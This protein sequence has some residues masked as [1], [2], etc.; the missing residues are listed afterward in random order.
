MAYTVQPTQPLA[1]DG[2]ALGRV[3][4]Q[5]GVAKDAAV[6]VT[7]P[8]ALT[9]V[10][11]LYRHGYAKAAFVHATHVATMEAADALL[12][13]HTCGTRELAAVLQGGGCLREGGVLIVQTPTELV[14]EGYDTIDGLLLRLGYLV[15][16]RVAEK[17]RHIY[18][19]RRQGFGGFK[20]AA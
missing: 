11:W 10:F 9:A 5:A 1:A 20:Q 4:Q 14:P 7:G 17:G 2:A 18:I 12:I 19:A 3:L 15:E 8:A 16:R 6:R 13:P